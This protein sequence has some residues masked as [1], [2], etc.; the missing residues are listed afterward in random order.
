M[1]ELAHC[2]PRRRLWVLAAAAI[3]SGPQLPSL[4][5]DF[6]AMEARLSSDFK[7]LQSGAVRPAPVAAAL[8]AF[9]ILSARRDVSRL[10]DDEDTFRAM[11]RIGL[12]TGTLQMPP[13]ILFNLFKRLEDQ[14]SNPDVFMDG[15]IEYI[16]YTRDANDLLELARLS[17][18]NGGGARLVDDYL[19]RSLDAA[20]GA[21]RA[22]DRMIPLLPKGL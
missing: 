14:S 17:R 18:T 21:S 7:S 6:P 11:V 13:I 16:E 3:C 1:R 19:D 15:A 5:A 10:L 2:V 8:D 12:P 22:L 4:A 9:P 20:R